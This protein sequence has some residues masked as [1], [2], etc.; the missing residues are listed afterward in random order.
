MD[1]Y[2]DFGSG[3]GDKTSLSNRQ[4]VPMSKKVFGININVGPSKMIFGKLPSLPSKTSHPKAMGAK[5][6]I[7]EKIRQAERKFNES[8]KTCENNHDL[9]KKDN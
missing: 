1:P 5:R 3:L 8:Q 6:I 2:I 9:C 7:G 4:S